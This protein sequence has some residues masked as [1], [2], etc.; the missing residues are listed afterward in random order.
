[1]TEY[2]KSNDNKSELNEP[3][4]AY[5]LGITTL[6]LLIDI[7]GISNL[8]K[9]LKNSLDLLK[10]AENGFPIKVLKNLQKRTQ[11]TN[12]QIGIVL[13]MSESTVQRR[14]RDNQKLDK[15]QSE[16]AV[17]LAS[18]WVKGLEVFEDEDDFRTWLNTENQ[19]LGGNKP[20]ALLHSSIGREEVK[21]VLNRIAWGIYS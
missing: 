4:M 12:R 14:I 19:A 8:A 9:K 13:D 20:L 1:M 21:N 11:F 3:A 15:K 2:K 17:Q 10:M 16:S 5:G 18:V 7:L 6:D